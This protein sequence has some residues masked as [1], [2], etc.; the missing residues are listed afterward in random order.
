M[1]KQLTFNQVKEKHFKTLEQYVPIVDRVHGGNHPE[2]HEVRQLFEAIAKKTKGAGAEKPELN[3]ELAKLRE[4]TH[5]YTV[6]RDVCESYEAVYNMLAEVDKA[7][8]A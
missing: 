1:S 2:F 7:Y 8:Q 6:P 4:V 3:E 5:N